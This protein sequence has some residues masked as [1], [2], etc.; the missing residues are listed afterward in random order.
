MI[1]TYRYWPLRKP[2]P[3]GW[4]FVRRML[5]NHGRYSVLIVKVA[6]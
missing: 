6:A 1:T 2:I 5:G 4:R 3:R